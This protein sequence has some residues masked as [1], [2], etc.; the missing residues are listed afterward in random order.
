MARRFLERGR[1]LVPNDE[2]L[3]KLGLRIDHVKK[4]FGIKS[5]PIRKRYAPPK[6]NVEPEEKRG[7]DRS[8]DGD[9]FPELDDIILK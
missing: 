8:A 3:T 6:K 2:R 1:K 9:N 5:E 7:Y 4:K